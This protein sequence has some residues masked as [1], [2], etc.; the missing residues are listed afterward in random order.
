MIAIYISFRKKT[1]STS[2][3]D[4]S[5]LLLLA[6]GFRCTFQL[7]V[8]LDRF[9]GRSGRKNDRITIGNYANGFRLLSELV[10]LVL[11]TKM[12]K[13]AKKAKKVSVH[14]NKFA[15]DKCKLAK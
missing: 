1:R 4:T 3:F 5:F 15:V 13:K 2:I 11:Q 7:N 14:L 9:S 10:R 12:A 8:A 6:D